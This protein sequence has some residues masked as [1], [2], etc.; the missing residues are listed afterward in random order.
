VTR[1]QRQATVVGV[2]RLRSPLG[3]TAGCTSKSFRLEIAGY[4]GRA[5]LPGVQ[6][7][8]DTPTSVAPA[9]ESWARPAIERYATMERDG[10]PAD[11]WF[12]GIA[13]GWNVA[14]RRFNALFVRAL[15]CELRLPTRSLSHGEYLYGLGAPQGPDVDAVFSH[16][17]A[18]FQDLGVWVELSSNQ[19]M[20]PD[21]P[22]RGED[23]PGEGLALFSIESGTVSIPRDATHT[24]VIVRDVEPINLPTLRALA[25]N[26]N[27][28]IGAS[29]AHLLVRD[30]RAQL[31][32][33]HTRRA[34]IDAGTAVELALAD[35]NRL[36]PKVN[37]GSG[38]TLGWYV[39]QP[40]IAAGA[41]VPASTQVELVDI[42]N[43]AIHRNM[44]PSHA[45]AD[46]ALTLAHDIVARLEPLPL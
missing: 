31:R 39:K 44:L 35:Y 45:Q 41:A 7:R 28:Q 17:D 42:R 29:D 12:W 27:S 10:A 30:G 18:W 15:A 21:D 33:N 8:R 43:A 24:N 19:D 32:R 23:T 38:Q 1:R 25:R 13:S 16:I 40:R 22:L 36:G 14:T 37:T 3:V 26:V 9:V 5:I 46:R 6:W 20:D 11:P 34:V 2:Y 4:S